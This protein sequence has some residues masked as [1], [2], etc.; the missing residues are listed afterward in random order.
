M[1][2]RR[3]SAFVMLTDILT[4]FGVTEEQLVELARQA[5]RAEVLTDPR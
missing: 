1:A 2:R 3:C 5:A 4:P